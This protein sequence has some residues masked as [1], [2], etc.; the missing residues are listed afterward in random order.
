MNR[1]PTLHQIMAWERA[2]R[3]PA[4]WRLRVPGLRLSWTR[5][6]DACR[7]VWDGMLE[8]SDA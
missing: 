8:S 4:L 2:G 7:V 5:K 1:E 3:I 6:G